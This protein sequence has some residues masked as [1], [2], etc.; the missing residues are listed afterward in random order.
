[1][2]HGPPPPAVR[3]DLTVEREEVEKERKALGM[4]VKNEEREKQKDPC[5]GLR[6]CGLSKTFPGGILSDTAE[7][8]RALRNLWIE[9]NEGECLGIMGHNGAGKTTLVNV[10]SGMMNPTA[11]NARIYN[12]QLI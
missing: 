7:D 12:Q 9:V 2:R 6:I 10:I 3:L 11:G 1:M 5:T 4:I 8:V